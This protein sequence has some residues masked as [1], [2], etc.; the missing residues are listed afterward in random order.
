MIPE[1]PPK[2]EKVSANA[3]VSGSG[4]LWFRVRL[5]LD[6]SWS[7]TTE[8]GRASV[9]SGLPS[10][11]VVPN[12]IVPLDGAEAVCEGEPLSA[13]F[14]VTANEP[15]PVGTPVTAPLLALSVK[16]AGKVPEATE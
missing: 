14:S 2:G 12:M 15:G 13:T 1:L 8:P 9:N 16:P 7:G 6:K 11:V 4:E 5:K 10:P 3:T